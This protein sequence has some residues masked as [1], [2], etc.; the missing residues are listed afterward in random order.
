MRASQ[1]LVA[2]LLVDS[3]ARGRYEKDP[4]G[5]LVSGGLSEAEARSL[6]DQISLRGLATS[7]RIAARKRLSRARRRYATVVRALEALAEEK[8]LFALADVPFGLRHFEQFRDELHSR[9][10]GWGDPCGRCLPA[11]ATYDEVW[12]G[13]HGSGPAARDARLAIEP[14]ATPDWRDVR[15]GENIA[16]LELDSEVPDIL[17]DLEAQPPRFT[18]RPGRSHLTLVL[19][20]NGNIATV[21]VPRPFYQLAQRLKAGQS[22]DEILDQHGS[23][24]LPVLNALHSIDGLVR[25]EQDGS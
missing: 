6:A 10:R 17:K 2:R 1:D 18:C 13:L 8:R 15:L 5:Y 9:S 23:G 24:I 25:A 4:V 3:A 22:V 11:L 12:S 19:R 7:A 21:K 16:L 20:R 14:G